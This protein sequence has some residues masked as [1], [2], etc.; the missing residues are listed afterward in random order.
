MTPDAALRA[1][2]ARADEL[3]AQLAEARELLD[4]IQAGD[5]DAVVVGGAGGDARIYTLTDAD[6]PYRLLIEQMR[7]GAVTLGADG[8]ILYANAALAELLGAEASDLTGRPL[9]GFVVDAA[10]RDRFDRLLANEGKGEV[11]LATASGSEVFAQIA[12][13]AIPSSEPPGHALTC[14]VVTDLTAEKRRSAEL[15]AARA[16]IAAAAVRR[17]GED[18]LRASEAQLR[19]ALHAGRFGA[20]TLD[21]ANGDLTTSDIC[22]INFGRDVAAPFGYDD[23]RGAVH[24]DDRA[25][26]AAAVD[27]TIATGA[28]YDIEYRVITPAGEVRWVLIRAQPAYGPDGAP[29]SLTGVSIDITTR[30]RDEAR[31]SCL[32]ELADAIRDAHDPDDLAYAAAA[33]LGR[34]LGVSRVG[35]A[36]I[37]PEL[38]TLHVGRNWT[39]PGV[40]SM[41]GKLHLRDYG[42]FV[43]SLK[44]GDLVAI[45]DIRDDHRTA[46]AAAALEARRVRAFVNQPVVEQGRLRAVL[47]V[48]HTEAREWTP[49]D[50]ALVKEIGERT[51]TA[52]ERARV[53]AALRDS[54][55]RYRTLFES[56]ESGFC[57]FEMV[58]DDDGRPVDYVFLEVN[59]AFAAQTGLHDALGRRIS[60]LAPGHEQLWYDLYGEIALTG[61]PI[62]TENYAHALGR[63]YEIY[64][65]R[66]G[67]PEQRRVAA[68]F[69]DVS[70]RKR[71][72]ARIRELNETLEARV[73]E[74]TAER[75]RVWQGSRDILVVGDRD[76]V[77]RDVNPAW[78]RILGHLPDAVIGQDFRDFVWPDDLAPTAAAIAAAAGDDIDGLENR[79]R[80]LD[81]TPRWLSWRTSYEYGVVYGYGRDITADRQAAADLALAQEALRQSQKM[82]AMGSL[83]GGVAHDF[84]NLLTPIVGSLDLLQRKGLGG[85][86]EQ[87]LIAGALQSADRA[88][89]LVQRLL[90]FARRQPLQPTPVDLAPL[91]RGMADLVASTT[92]PQIK[93]VVDA[94][95]GLPPAKA[96]PNQL[97][98]AILNLAVNARDAMPDGGTLRISVDAATA[99][100]GHPA[101]IPPGRY[102]RLSVADTG[103]GMDDATLKR[104]VEPFF[105]TKGVGKGT[106]LGLS[107]AHGLASQLGGALTIRSTPAVGTNVE[108]WLPQSV[109]PLADSVAAVASAPVATGSGTAL[110]VDDE[111]LVRLSTADMLSELGYTVVEAASAEEALR[112]IDRGLQPDL[113]VTD[114][115]MPGI[116]G[117]TLAR[118]VLANRP[119]IKVIVVSGYAETEGI[120][121]D[122]PRLTKPFRNADLAESLAALG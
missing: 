32:V 56:V 21:L 114:H 70:E 87:R 16:A 89:T 121:P 100:R 97:E 43:D 104:A 40:E 69:N 94:V 99:G 26:M 63:W 5:V 67:P 111:D 47:C 75:N 101:G 36:T 48:D 93:V 60:E 13:S 41:P 113:L 17:E 112:L 80:A 4:A 107:M 53:D 115:L 117:S 106:G 54:E 83:T 39:A 33:I 61:A 95:D 52:V 82:E 72:E 108:L 88:K 55:Q 19:F 62:R 102:L 51:R 57:V 8:T 25:R 66:V 44:C 110:L 118:T 86:R 27:A 77:I 74:R 119:G 105:S 103:S 50:L 68:L 122:L 85:E 14:A 42:S 91:V 34:A 29:R 7:E 59:P 64:A 31:K 78:T 98:M 10:N 24:P 109:A 37:D 15:A 9:C 18:A 20:W 46:A 3:A 35:Y 11:A 90:A 6:R 58:F 76:G 92:G 65:Y 30:K 2:R 12:F 81:G 45:A 84:N 71:A 49:D 96:D 79:Y 120:E 22:R 28:D 38:E 73:A 1:E 116:S 23:L